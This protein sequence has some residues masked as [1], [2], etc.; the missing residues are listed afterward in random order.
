MGPTA[1]GK[2]QIAERLADA[3]GARLVNADAFQVYRGLD[4]GTA[5]P[6][7]R[8]RYALIDIKDPEESFGVGEFVERALEA[9]HSAPGPV[10]VVGGTGL[11]IRALTEGYADMRRM[12]DP[13]LRTALEE[14]ERTHGL[15]ALVD[16][17]RRLDPQRASQVDTLNPVRV[18]R[19]LERALAPGDPI[20]PLPLPGPVVKIG[21]YVE[22][23][24]LGERI[25]RR[26]HEM[27]D[28]GWL[29]EVVGLAARGVPETAP[30]MRAIGYRAML[31]LASNSLDRV[32]TIEQVRLETRRY[33]KRQ[34]T[35][36]RSEPRLQWVESN[37]PERAFTFCERLIEDLP[38]M[39]D[40]N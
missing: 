14:E 27:L 20:K 25:D 1:S 13:A 23:E 31:S 5:K 8:D 10:V 18:R 28:A 7:A 36:L 11:Y 39:F 9:I 6:A 15:P 19:A 34:R 37:D 38:K 35:W 22:P 40:A 12:P 32:E 33:A 21:L 16:K 3:L 4:I 2:T 24:L 29:E 30:A 26:V 17:L